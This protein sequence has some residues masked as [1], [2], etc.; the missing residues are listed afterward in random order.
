MTRA[1]ANHRLDE[2]CQ[3]GGRRLAC[4]CL[5]F[6]RQSRVTFDSRRT[7]RWSLSGTGFSTWW[8]VTAIEAFEPL[9]M[10][11][12][13][14]AGGSRICHH[15]KT[16]SF[17]K[18]CK[19]E[20]T[21]GS[22]ICDHGRK[23]S[24]CKSCKAE[25][26]GGSR[27]CDHGQTRSSCKFCNSGTNQNS[28]VCDHRN[29]H[30][31]CKFC[32]ARNDENAVIC[33]HN[34]NRSFCMFCQAK[35]AEKALIC[36]HESYRVSCSIC[37]DAEFQTCS[38]VQVRKHCKHCKEEKADVSQICNHGKYGPMCIDCQIE[39]IGGKKLCHHAFHRDFC[40]DCK[41]VGVGG[42]AGK[43]RQEAPS[44][45]NALE[46]PSDA[47]ASERP[48]KKVKLPPYTPE[49][50]PHASSSKTTSF[51]EI[52]AAGLVSPPPPAP[53]QL[54]EPPADRG[55]L[56]EVLPVAVVCLAPPLSSQPPM[57]DRA[58]SPIPQPRPQMVDRATSPIPQPEPQT[59]DRATSP[60]SFPEPAIVEQQEVEIYTTRAPV[61]F[62]PP[63]FEN[64]RFNS[65][66]L[67]ARKPAAAPSFAP[68]V[69]LSLSA[70][71]FSSVALGMVPKPVVV[72]PQ[73]PASGASSAGPPGEAQEGVGVKV[74]G[75]ACP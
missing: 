42:S 61:P 69:L 62:T 64:F 50:P 25:G 54:R 33:E 16:R 18:Y 29:Y 40:I 56:P 30:S 15:R 14:R 20:G 75:D 67:S 43:K 19:V 12:T 73:G 74:E 37:Q 26:T 57:V 60:L 72:D 39:G 70:P 5:V 11:G 4:A 48:R 68:V 34:K 24:I 8:G 17:C 51:S 3:L 52:L 55:T 44:D 28:Q 23:R 53:A 38:H 47:N 49:V 1:A 31:S 7:F 59:S 58:T 65:P 6:S 35:D 21:G 10:G 13:G 63:T 22:N 46:P 32:R 45:T 36:E 66:P 27:I 2:S 41:G 71:S 9:Q